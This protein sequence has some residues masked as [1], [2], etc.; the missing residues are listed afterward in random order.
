MPPKKHGLGRGLDALLPV[1][2]QPEGTHEVAV[3][4]IRR[5]P[6]QPRSG[7]AEMP[8]RRALPETKHPAR[9]LR[10][11]AARSTSVSGRSTA[12]LNAGA[13]PPAGL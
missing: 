13:L 6:R 12:L 8:A 1:E 4:L 7:M 5:N 10:T 11:P 3:A 9:S 2:E